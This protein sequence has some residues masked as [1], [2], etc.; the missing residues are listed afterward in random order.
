METF[1]ATGGQREE[2]H[3]SQHFD[4]AKLLQLDSPL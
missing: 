4:L 2:I 1:W 3:G